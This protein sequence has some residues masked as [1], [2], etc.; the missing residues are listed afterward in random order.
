MNKFKE[1]AAL[2]RLELGE[3]FNVRFKTGE[4]VAYCP[5]KFV[6]DGLIDCNGVKAINLLVRMLGGEVTVEKL[7]WKPNINE[8]YYYVEESGIF[9]YGW[10]N[11]IFDIMCF[12]LGNCFKTEE[13][14]KQNIDKIMNMLEE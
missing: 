8:R 9:N 6:N 14:A 10:T 12:K 5:F 3:K 13:E 1:V 11:E 4:K 7:P 2:F